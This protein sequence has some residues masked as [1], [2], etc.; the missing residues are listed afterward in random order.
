MQ[1][2]IVVSI[3]LATAVCWAGCSKK[4]A[5]MNEAAAVKKSA[6]GESCARSSDCDGTLRCVANTCVAAAGPKAAVA[7]GAAGEESA[8]TASAKTDEDRAAMPSNAPA[9]AKHIAAEANP[10]PKAPDD[11]KFEYTSIKPKDCRRSAAGDGDGLACP[12]F[13]ESMV[14]IMPFDYGYYLQ[15]RTGGV[16]IDLH[17]AWAQSSLTGKVV[18]WRYRDKDG[19]RTAHGLIYRVKNMLPGSDGESVLMVVR[20]RGSKSCVVGSTKSNSDARKM[21]DDMSKGCE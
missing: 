21:A 5:P 6:T 11:V 10:P 17:G 14:F 8:S 3:C 15:L 7:G 4:S 20:L 2:P 13:G 19:K 16:P 18:E 9:A 12:T 1:R